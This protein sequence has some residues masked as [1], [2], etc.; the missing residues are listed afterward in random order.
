MQRPRDERRSVVATAACI[1]W[2]DAILYLSLLTSFSRNYLFD[3]VFHFHP[4][5]VFVCDLSCPLLHIMSSDNDKV[6]DDDTRLENVDDEEFSPSEQRKILRRADVR[7]LGAT[8][9]G[10]S[11]SLMDRGNV[12]LAAVAG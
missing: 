11:I 8:A 6:I 9:L 3:R 1:Y 2:H 7:L 5:Q 4:P 12:S 10:Y